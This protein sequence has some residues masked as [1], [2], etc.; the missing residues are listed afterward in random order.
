MHADQWAYPGLYTARCEQSGSASW[1]QSTQPGFPAI[2]A[3]V[4]A[5]LG[6][7]WGP[8]EDVNLA[9]G[10]LIGDVATQESAWSPAGSAAGLGHRDVGSL[11]VRRG[12]AERTF[13]VACQRCGHTTD[14][15]PLDLLVFQFP[16]G[17]WRPL[18]PYDRRMTCPSCRRRAWCSVTLRRH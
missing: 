14:V 12:G 3:L 7:T 13:T 2:H 11:V 18:S 15:G 4:S 9:L 17:L 1:P 8:P 16:V 6:P 10:D 5:V